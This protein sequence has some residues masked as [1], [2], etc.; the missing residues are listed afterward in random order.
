VET[1]NDQL[2]EKEESKVKTPADDPDA[3]S[4]IQNGKIITFILAG[5]LVIAAVNSYYQDG[6]IEVFYIYGPIIFIYLAL[7]VFYY[8]NPYIA[9][10]IGLSLYLTLQITQSILIP[11][12]F[13]NGML[14]KILIIALWFRCIK[15][16]RYYKGMG[17]QK[18]ND[19]LDNDLP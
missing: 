5:L 11:G 2:E 1:P 14:F 16:A 6:L 9:S 10:I 3:E 12:S 15:F 17:K 18:H 8:R 19:L 7:G 13:I 4:N